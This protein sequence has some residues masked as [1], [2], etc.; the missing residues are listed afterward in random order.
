MHHS[1]TNAMVGNGKHVF[2]GISVMLEVKGQPNH[3]PTTSSRP[4]TS[5]Y[6]YESLRN[7]FQQNL[8]GKDRNRGS[9]LL[10]RSSWW[11]WIAE[12]QFLSWR[13]PISKPW[14][15]GGGSSSHHPTTINQSNYHSLQYP[16][17]RSR[18]M[19]KISL[20][21]LLPSCFKLPKSSSSSSSDRKKINTLQSRISFSDLSNP[22]S[23]ISPED[24]SL[25]LIGSDLHVFT[26]GELREITK[27][28]SSSNFL[29]EGGFG[30]VHKGF[31][32][33][34]I[35]PGLKAQPVA[36]KLLDLEG[37]QGHREWLVSVDN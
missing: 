3:F 14:K 9:P 33:E 29:G 24:L 27:N 15:L 25:S 2:K 16:F 1:Y 19:C 11:A 34:K 7:A 13:T 26:L 28:F 36:V 12:I 5:I 22:A 18:M 20:K 31:V 17:V 4:G 35:R 8:G 32:D 23:P 30:P 21:S 10:H 6:I 37:A